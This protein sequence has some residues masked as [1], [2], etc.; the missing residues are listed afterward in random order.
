MGTQR[1]NVAPLV[2]RIATDSRVM[3]ADKIK[4]GKTIDKEKKTTRGGGRDGGDAI[5][6]N[7]GT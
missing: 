6:G 5:Q 1:S 4:A 7:R 3:R 2:E